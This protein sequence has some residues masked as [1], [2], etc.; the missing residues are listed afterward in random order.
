M[1]LRSK[2]RQDGARGRHC[3]D[4][5][6]QVPR[7]TS[8]AKEDSDRPLACAKKKGSWDSWRLAYRDRITSVEVGS[9]RESHG[10][11]T[12]TFKIASPASVLPGFRPPPRTKGTVA[13]GRHENST[14]TFRFRPFRMTSSRRANHGRAQEQYLLHRHHPKLLQS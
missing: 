13:P 4:L 6:P 1:C 7:A 3:Q 12:T 10:R 14:V 5:F 8:F 11:L 9:R 2:D